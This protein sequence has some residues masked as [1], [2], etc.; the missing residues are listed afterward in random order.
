MQALHGFRVQFLQLYFCRQYSASL[1]RLRYH[2]PR[3]N[4]NSDSSDRV[5]LSIR[6][7]REMLHNRFLHRGIR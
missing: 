2:D 5:R 3:K 1:S 4:G 7:I 6:T